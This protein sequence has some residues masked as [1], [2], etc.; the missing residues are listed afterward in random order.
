MKKLTLRSL[1]EIFLERTNINFNDKSLGD[2]MLFG[3][4]LNIRPRE[5]LMIYMDLKQEYKICFSEIDLLEKKI[6][7]F[8]GIVQTVEKTC[9]YSVY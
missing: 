3:S 2:E 6:S 1:C 9:G 5:L 7:T 4:R 8:N